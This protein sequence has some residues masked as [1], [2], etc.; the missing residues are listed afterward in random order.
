MVENSGVLQSAGCDYITCTTRQPEA[1]DSVLELSADLLRLE[2]EK[3]NRVR[4]W[5]MAGFEG[6]HCGSMQF[7]I[8]NQETIMRLSSEL[9]HT[10]WRKAFELTKHCTR[11]DV[12]CTSFGTQTAMQRISRAF[13]EARARARKKD[14]RRRLRYIYGP[15]GP[16][17][18]YVGSR[19]SDVF[20]RIYDKYAESRDE[21]YRGC[22]RFEIEFKGKRGLLV[23]RAMLAH[24]EDFAFAS[25]CLPGYLLAAGISS[26]FD[27]ACLTPSEVRRRKSDRARVLSWLRKGVKPSVLALIRQGNPAEVVDALGLTDYIQDQWSRPLDHQKE[28]SEP[29]GSLASDYEC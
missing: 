14:R 11:F 17:T 13:T 12:Q 3:G 7:G 19:Q 10:F 25:A 26:E 23:A 27:S 28:G 16:Q 9:A 22:V 6:A 8:R 4:P 15:E 24:T 5:G 21:R 2:Q 1:V 18:L 29:D 20:I